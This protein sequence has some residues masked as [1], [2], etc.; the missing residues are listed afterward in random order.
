[1][2]RT[3]IRL[4]DGAEISIG[5]VGVLKNGGSIYIGPPITDGSFVG[6]HQSV[7]DDTS[8]EL[9]HVDLKTLVPMLVSEKLSD[10][11]HS[12]CAKGWGWENEEKEPKKSAC[13]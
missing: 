2:P 12:L 4:K 7:Y 5:G 3:M 1:M 9:G 6:Q 13:G 11:Y 10:P 8:S